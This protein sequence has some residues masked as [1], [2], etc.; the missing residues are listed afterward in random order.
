MAGGGGAVAGVR[1]HGWRHPP[2][3]HGLPPRGHRAHV[4]G[5]GEAG[6]GSVMQG[7][8]GIFIIWIAFARMELGYPL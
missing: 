8:Q 3:R 5:C 4:L 1:R 2:G 6:L 7:E